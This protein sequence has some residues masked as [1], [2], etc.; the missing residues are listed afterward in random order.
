MKKWHSY[1]VT[2]TIAAAALASCSSLTTEVKQRSSD[3]LSSIRTVDLPFTAVEAH[4][5]GWYA[6]RSDK[7]IRGG[8]FSFTQNMPVGLSDVKQVSSGLFHT[9][10]LKNDGTTAAWGITSNSLD[11]A[12]LINVPA[13]AQ[14]G[15]KAVSANQ[16]HTLALRTD[17]TVVGWGDPQF[18]NIPL[19]LAQGG[20][21]A[22]S[23]G[24]FHNLALRNDGTVIAWGDSIAA[25]TGLINSY[26]YDPTNWQWKP[27]KD[28]GT[29]NADATFDNPGLV[30]EGPNNVQAIAA[31]GNI[32]VALK[33]D[34]T[35]ISWGAYPDAPVAPAGEYFV[36][37]AAGGTYALALTNTGRVVGWGGENLGPL[38]YTHPSIVPATVNTGSKVIE[39]SAGESCAVALRENGHVETWGDQSLAAGITCQLR[40]RARIF[41]PSCRMARFRLQPIMGQI[42]HLFFHPLLHRQPLLLHLFNTSPMQPQ[43]AQAL[44]LRLH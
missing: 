18:S 11:W 21:S 2:G 44:V 40:Y 31:A 8:E 3:G 12:S 24:V 35:L 17:G 15:V 6:I 36:K 22:I 28:D 29:L 37:I 25:V 1:F 38:P 27:L 32:S 4:D 7:A 16:A 9:I 39:I 43:S 23:A 5:N 10:A 19:F 26:N 42:K 41:E 34:G 13:T 20:T 14:T 33:N 30:F